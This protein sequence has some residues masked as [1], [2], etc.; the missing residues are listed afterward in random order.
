VGSALISE[1][2]I[3]HFSRKRFQFLERSPFEIEQILFGQQQG[4][5]PQTS[6]PPYQTPP[7]F[8]EGQAEPGAQIPPDTQAP[9]PEQMSSRQVEGQIVKGFRAEPALRGTNIDA[10]VNDTSVVLKGSVDTMTQHDLAHRIAQSHAGNRKVVD[11]I[12]VRQQA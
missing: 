2:H 9:P 1:A 3:R 12:T 11:R 7:T 10:E 4:Q 8:P 5:G 6:N